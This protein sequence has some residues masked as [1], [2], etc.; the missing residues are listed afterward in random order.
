[1]MQALAHGMLVPSPALEREAVDT[2]LPQIEALLGPHVQAGDARARVGLF[3]ASSNAGA[4]TSLAFW[5]QA[6]RTG[7]AFANPE[8]FPWCLANAPCGAL[9]RHLGI[10]F[11]GGADALFDALEAA[12]DLLDAGRIAF[13]LIVALD[14]ADAAR[15]APGGVA[16]VVAPGPLRAG[17]VLRQLPAG[18]RD[19]PRSHGP[20]RP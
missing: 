8:L 7:P 9:A 2:V 11:L 17:E 10:T 14:F 16:L 20:D 15:P 5:S 1:M 18:V 6:Q 13:G 3:V 4:A 12:H 19:W